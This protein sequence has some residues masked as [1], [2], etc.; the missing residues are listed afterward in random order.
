[1]F[2]PKLGREKRQIL[3]AA[4]NDYGDNIQPRVAIYD[5]LCLWIRCFKR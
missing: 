4:Q 3:E 1:M 2:L 5:S